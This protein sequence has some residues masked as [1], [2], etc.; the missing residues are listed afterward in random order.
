MSATPW[1]EWID[2]QTI[3]ILYADGISNYGGLRSPSKD[4]C[5]DGALGAAYNAELYSMPEVDSETVVTGIC[6][7]GYLLYYL[8]AKHCF[9]DGNKRVAWSSAMWVLEG[10][11]L[12]I[13]APDQDAIDY[14]LAIADGKIESGED[15]V[16]W[17][18]D[19]LVEIQE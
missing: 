19:R 17:L 14:V 1:E 10:M 9:A 8:A 18:A 4:G 11:G 16:N 5:V 15:V 7:C 3:H 13:D 2:N 12:T 6:F